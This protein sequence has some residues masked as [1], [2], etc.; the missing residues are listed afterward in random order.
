MKLTRFRRAP[1][2]M[3]LAFAVCASAAPQ[4]REAEG[5]PIRIAVT[6]VAKEEGREPPSLVKEDF[7]VYQ[8]RGRRRVLDAV[9]LSGE[10]NKIDLYIF[11]DDATRSNVTLDFREIGSFVGELPASARVGVIYA[12]NGTFSVAQ[13]LTHDREAALKTLRK[14]LGSVAANGGIYLSLAELGKRLPPSPDRRRAVILL[15]SGIDV[16]RGRSESSSGVNPDLELA[17]NHLAESEVLVYPIYVSPAAEVLSNLALVA[18]GQSCLKRLATET[19]GEAFWEGFGTPVTMKPYLD[20]VSRDLK[21]QYWVTFAAKPSK[22]P[23]YAEIR[24]KTE[25]SGVRVIGP[26]RA[27]VPA[28]R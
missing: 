14:P 15:S 1:A 12:R 10:R 11:V 17:I 7:L 23:D 26:E 28:G 21:N 27:W 9:R 25:V 19:G 16:L 6:A 18:N 5:V 13:E 22:K 4:A 24:V 2:F 3:L 8:D 20:D